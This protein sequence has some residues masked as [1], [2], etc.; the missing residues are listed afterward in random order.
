MI[1]LAGEKPVIGLSL[2]TLKEEDRVFEHAASRIHNHLRD[3]EHYLNSSEYGRE[4]LKLFT[5][6]PYAKKEKILIVDDEL[7]ILQLL[8][9]LLED[10]C[11]IDLAVNGAEAL[12]K[13]KTTSY[14]LVISDLDMPVMNGLELYR[15]AATLMRRP[16]ENFLFHTGNLTDESRTFFIA[17]AISFMTKPSSI[18]QIKNAV[19]AKFHRYQA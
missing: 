18:M 4:K 12:E 13:I 6:L 3:I 17:N 14:D 16:S 19:L 10:I 9:A 1:R 7:P 11:D 8:S 15:N 2:D 5:K